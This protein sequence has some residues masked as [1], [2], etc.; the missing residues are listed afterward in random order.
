[1]TAALDADWHQLHL[2]SRAFTAQLTQARE[3]VRQIGVARQIRA[4]LLQSGDAL[5][6]RAL[7]LAVAAPMVGWLQNPTARLVA[8]SLR[9]DLAVDQRAALPELARLEDQL[10]RARGP[11]G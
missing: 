2:R 10:A 5:G 7:R 9:R 11:L 8:R 6:L 4:A 3:P 1:M